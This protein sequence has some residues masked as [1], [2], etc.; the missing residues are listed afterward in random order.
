MT[1]RD[2]NKTILNIKNITTLSKINNINPVNFISQATLRI[3][4]VDIIYLSENL[5]DE[6]YDYIQ[7]VMNR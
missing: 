5:R 2:I 1:C 3:N 7:E 4:G 6:D